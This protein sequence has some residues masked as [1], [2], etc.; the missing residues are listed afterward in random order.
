MGLGLEILPWPIFEK[1]GRGRSSQA[2]QF[3][4][5]LDRYC[6]SSVQ[7]STCSCSFWDGGR[8]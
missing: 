8:V 1:T 7:C 3:M 6:E 5:L 4:T 2:R